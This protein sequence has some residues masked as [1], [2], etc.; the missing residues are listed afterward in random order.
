MLL[1]QNF[2]R[3]H[4]RRLRAAFHRIKHCQQGDNGFAAADVSLQQPQ[5]TEFGG[6]IGGDF[7]QDFFLGRC[8][9]KG[10]GV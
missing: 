7:P 1:G 2:G 8:Q 3:C 6:L 5:H 4:N 10:Q 9:L